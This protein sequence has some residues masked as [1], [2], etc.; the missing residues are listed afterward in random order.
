MGLLAAGDEVAT[1]K[2]FL[3]IVRDYWPVVGAGIASLLVSFG[4]V[5]KQMWTK[6]DKWMERR[7]AIAEIEATARA[8]A[9]KLKAVK[10]AKAL[11]TMS[12]SLPQIAENGKQVSETLRQMSERQNDIVRTQVALHAGVVDFADA[13]TLNA[14]PDVAERFKK[15]VERGKNR[16]KVIDPSLKDTKRP[17][18]P[19]DFLDRHKS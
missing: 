2:G 19:P 18:A 11:E 17:D 7:H 9:A 8:E 13:C 6:F 4:W 1:A 15:D 16:M 10:E 5:I 14:C 3:D 12:E